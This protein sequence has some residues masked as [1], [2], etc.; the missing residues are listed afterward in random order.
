MDPTAEVVA[1][2]PPTAHSAKKW[3]MLHPDYEGGDGEL[4]WNIYYGDFSDD[5]RFDAFRKDQLWDAEVI[6]PIIAMDVKYERF[7]LNHEALNVSH[8]KS[9]AS[10]HEWVVVASIALVIVA[11]FAMWFKYKRSYKQIA[12]STESQGL[13]QTNPT[14]GQ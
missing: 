13:L 7:Q 11:A 6:R 14:Y 9:K 1:T 4:L 5:E 3:T 12:D 10:G 8:G 2:P